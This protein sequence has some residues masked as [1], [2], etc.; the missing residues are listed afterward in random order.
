MIAEADFET[1]AALIR[2]GQIAQQDAPKLLAE[3]PAFAAW[4]R[5][6]FK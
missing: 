2:S 6:H 4:Y 1:W 5:E 3:N